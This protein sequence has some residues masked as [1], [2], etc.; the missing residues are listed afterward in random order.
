MGRLKNIKKALLSER[1]SLHQKNTFGESTKKN[2]HLNIDEILLQLSFP[3]EF[4][5]IKRIKK[6][7]T[8][9]ASQKIIRVAVGNALN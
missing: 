8:R 1:E 9:P 2:L 6:S 4:S 5:H 7:S 3:K